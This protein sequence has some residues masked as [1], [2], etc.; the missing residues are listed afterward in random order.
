MTGWSEDFYPEV[1]SNGSKGAGI[2]VNEDI[3]S[4]GTIWATKGLIVYDN[5]GD[6]ENN[7]TV[8]DIRTYHGKIWAKDNTVGGNDFIFNSN[9]EGKVTVQRGTNQTEN[10]SSG[11]EEYT[12]KTNSVKTFIEDSK[13][14][15]GILNEIGKWQLWYDTYF[16]KWVESKIKSVITTWCSEPGIDGTILATRGWA[17]GKFAESGHTHDYAS[18]SHT[19]TV[20]EPATGGYGFIADAE[21]TPI[22]G[23][24]QTIYHITK[25]T[26][27]WS[28]TTSGPSS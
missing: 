25:R 8:G 26:T 14:L 3:W 27:N 18:S 15:I 7:S 22:K 24:D 2:L 20:S 4:K 16:Y 9:L 11:T 5:Y 6:Q 1:K 23:T 10:S 17:E 21:E 28:L 13:N 19:H 12:I